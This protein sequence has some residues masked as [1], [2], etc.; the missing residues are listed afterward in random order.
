MIIYVTSSEKGRKIALTISQDE[1]SKALHHAAHVVL[2]CNMF[3]LGRTKPR[4]ISVL[5]ASDVISLT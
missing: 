2:S 4:E 5:Q 1:G 3:N